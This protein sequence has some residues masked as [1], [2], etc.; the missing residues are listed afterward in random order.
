M[1][2]VGSALLWRGGSYSFGN[3]EAS[4]DA[5]TNNMG[6]MLAQDAQNANPDILADEENSLLNPKKKIKVSYFSHF[7]LLHH[8]P[9]HNA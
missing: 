7:V 4:A 9:I 8:A 1:A 6:N 2:N 3:A 5:T